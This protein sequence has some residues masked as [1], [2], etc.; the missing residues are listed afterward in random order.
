MQAWPGRRTCAKRQ[1]RL[2]R[3]ASASRAALAT[4]KGANTNIKKFKRPGCRGAVAGAQYPTVPGPRR[5]DAAPYG[6]GPR[7]KAPRPKS[8][9]STV[10]LDGRGLAAGPP[11]SCPANGP[12]PWQP[13]TKQG[14]GRQEGR[15]G[16]ERGGVVGLV[17]ARMPAVLHHPSILGRNAGAAAASYADTER[18]RWQ[19]RSQELQMAQASAHA[20]TRAVSAHSLSSPQLEPTV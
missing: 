8:R 4:D 11:D 18:Q 20:G 1:A 12:K 7:P 14:K 16:V 2:P 13:L 15:A 3:A 10:L 5:G 6:P 17:G 19:V 9:L